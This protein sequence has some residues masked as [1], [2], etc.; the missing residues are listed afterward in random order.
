MVEDAC[1]N[2]M[3]REMAENNYVN[4][5][6]ERQV[7]L[8]VYKI[9]IELLKYEGG[10]IWSRTQIFLSI[11]AVAIALS[12]WV[13]NLEG[14]V[15]KA[16]M[17]GLCIVSALLNLIW[18]LVI[19]HSRYYSAYWNLQLRAIES[20]L[21][22]FTIYRDLARL[23]RGEEVALQVAKLVAEGQRSPK[24]VETEKLFMPRFSRIRVANLLEV[25]A[26]LFA[27]SWL[28]AAVVSIFA[29]FKG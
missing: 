6:I 12:Q 22:P 14:G 21:S 13:G 17:I 10:L 5:G 1:L 25:V 27:V 7:R 2:I 9:L 19:R 29:V 28:L 4:S 24:E 8:E 26:W 3:F 11:N 20:E 15:S 23:R 18:V 16:V